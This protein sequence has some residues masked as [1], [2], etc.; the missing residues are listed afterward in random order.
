MTFKNFIEVFK[1]WNE[2]KE[3]PDIELPMKTKEGVKNMDKEFNEEDL[4]KATDEVAKKVEEET[5]KKVEAEFAEKQAKERAEIR[6][7][8]TKEW[9]DSKIKDGKILPAWDKMGIREFMGSLDGEKAFEFAETKSTSLDWFKSFIDE[10]PKTVEFKE[11]ADKDNDVKDKTAGLKIDTL[12]KK[13]MQE[14]QKLDYISAFNEVQVENPE[15]AKQYAIE[16]A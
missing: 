13:K 12:I 5:R 16:L 11:I 2:F 14:N 7:K 6:T 1:F 3:N 10:L 15:L 4:K 9:L 8:A